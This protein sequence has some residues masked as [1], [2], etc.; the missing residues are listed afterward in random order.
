MHPTVNLYYCFTFT[1]YGVLS[2]L[3]GLLWLLLFLQAILPSSRENAPTQAETAQH[4]NPDGLV[5]EV[6]QK[7]KGE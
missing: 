2:I 6:S 3:F 4:H 5:S 1:L 7:K